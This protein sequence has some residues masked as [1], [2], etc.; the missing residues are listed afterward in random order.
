MPLRRNNLSNMV[1]PEFRKYQLLA[2]D[3]SD[4]RSSPGTCDTTVVS[5]GG[6]EPQ[7]SLDSILCGLCSSMGNCKRA[8]VF[9]VDTNCGSASDIEGALLWVKRTKRVKRIVERRTSRGVGGE[10]AM[11]AEGGQQFKATTGRFQNPYF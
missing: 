2:R 1:Q 11:V 9:V 4:A 6:D 3:R 10:N 8:D 5:G 7:F